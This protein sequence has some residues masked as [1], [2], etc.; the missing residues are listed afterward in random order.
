MKNKSDDW[1]D[2]FLSAGLAEA[3]AAHYEGLFRANDMPSPSQ[4]ALTYVTE[5]LLTSIGITIPGHKAKIIQA[6]SRMAINNDNPVSE[7]YDQGNFLKEPT[8]S[9]REPS[10]ASGGSRQTKYSTINNSRP[11]RFISQSRRNPEII[12]DLTS[13]AA[14]V[15]YHLLP[16]KKVT[17]SEYGSDGSEVHWIDICG[18][19]ASFVDLVSKMASKYDIHPAFIKDL[20]SPVALPQFD[21]F[22]HAVFLIFRVA[23]LN[24][25]PA[26]DTVQEVTNKWVF[27]LRPKDNLILSV[28]RVDSQGIASLRAEETARKC[29][30][31]EFLDKFVCMAVSTYGDEMQFCESLLDNYESHL[32]DETEGSSKGRHSSLVTRLYH[33]H[34]RVSVCQR[35]LEMMLVVLKELRS[36]EFSSSI[37][38]RPET[39]D[40]DDEVVEHLTKAKVLHES[41]QNLLSLH[42]AL[43]SNHTNELMRVLTIFSVFFIPLTFIT[44]VYGMNFVNMPELHLE[45][46]Y[47][48]AFGLMLSTTVLI[49]TFF[50]RQGVL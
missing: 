33:L 19:D 44:G 34:R 3:S 30:I 15:E 35:M 17:L 22:N 29:E 5:A 6:L 4:D 7:A 10:S 43:L 50:H 9:W 28:H 39:Q 31:A 48:L 20:N 2:L 25:D 13:S 24:Q 16:S 47:P 21:D 36:H 11:T 18:K 45:Y 12:L 42:L 37:R 26:A 1:R 49:Y 46:G 27:F 40:I 38:L 23:A 32:L 14:R 41:C 8:T